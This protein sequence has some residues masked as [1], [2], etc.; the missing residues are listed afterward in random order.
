MKHAAI[1]L[2]LLFWSAS[3][4]SQSQ[5]LDYPVGI[6]PDLPYVDVSHGQQQIR[7]QRIQDETHVITG[8]YART[9]RHCPPFCINPIQVAPDV[10]TVGELELLQFVSRGAG[11]EKQL[12]I[13]ARTQ[14]WYERGTIPGSIHIPFTAF[15]ESEDTQA[16]Q[17]L[18]AQLGVI[19]RVAQTSWWSGLL[20]RLSGLMSRT[21]S[22][23]EGRWDFSDAKELMLW[24][25]GPWC[26]Q[27]PRA[28]RALLDIGYPAEKLYSYRGGMQMWQLFGLTVIIPE[29][30]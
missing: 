15:L 23:N 28:I 9:S 7:V 4:Q 3:A 27:S 18:M 8:S 20:D 13:D 10:K 19:P 21:A 30:Q 25:N 12:L 1:L 29:N 17:G 14:A 22:A 16:F 5:S 6:A 2:G 26:D 24:C 11:P